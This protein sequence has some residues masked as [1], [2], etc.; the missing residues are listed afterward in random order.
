[1]MC[2]NAGTFQLGAFTGQSNDTNL[3]GPQDTIFLCRN[4]Q[5]L[6]DHNG[7]SDLSG[8][9]QPAT[10]PGI[11]WAF[12]TCAPTVMGDNLATVLT[13]PCIL[14]GATNGIWV[15][16][17]QPNGDI[18]FIN[19]GGLQ[20]AFNSGQPIL[21]HFAPITLDVFATQGFE[22]N[23]AGPCVNV[24]TGVEFKVLYMNAIEESGVS[25]NFGNDCLGKFRIEGG[26]P[27][28]NTQA[29]YTITIT[30]ASDPTIKAVIHT[31][32][33]Q[34]FHG[35][36]V[37]F[38]VPQPGT[39]D[40]TV[41]DGK[42]CGHTFQINMAGCN[43][44]DNVV[45]ALPDTVSP[46]GST[47]CIPIT[48]QNFNLV[49][50][51][52]SLNWDPTILEFNTV[53]N[54][55]PAIGTFNASNLNTQSTAEGRLGAII[56]DQVN[57]GNVISIPD[58]ETLMEICFTVIGN[59]G[60]CT[61]LG[62][63]NSPSAIN[64]EDALGQAVA[65]TAIDGQLC[66]DFLPLSY[67]LSVV[68]TT[69]AGTASIEVT[70]T[71][72]TAPYEVIRQR[73]N[74]LGAVSIMNIPT[75]GGTVTYPGLSTGDYL[76]R[77][78]DNN[79][80]GT[81]LNDTVSIN[82]QT[83]GVALDVTSQLP[84]CNGFA[85]GVV[86]ASVLIGTTPV[87]NPGPP[88][89]TFNWLPA[90]VPNPT[91]AVQTGV[92]AGA[93]SVTVTDV[94]SQCTA[95]ASGALGQP[96]VISDQ[97]VTVAPASCTGICDGSI[98][99]TSTGGTPY[100]TSGSNT[101]DYS[102]EFTADVA[103]PPSPLPNG[104]GNSNP[105]LL[106][107]LCAGSYFVTITD[108]NGCTITDEVTLNNQRVLELVLNSQSNTTCA[109]LDNGSATVEVQETPPT[110]ATYNFFW[111]PNGFTQT[112]TA[113]TSTYDDL[114]AG[115]YNVLATDAAGCADTLT[116]V[117][118]SP[119]ELE[120]DTINLTQPSCTFQ[121]DGAISTFT[122]GGS[123]GPLYTYLWSANANNANTSFV[124]NLIPGTYTITVTDVN[125]CQDSLSFDLALP[126]PPTIDGI[127][128]VSVRCGSDGC[129][130]VLTSTGTNFTWQTLGGTVLPSNTAQI[131]DLP[132]GTYVVTVVDD[133]GC[134]TQD[135]LT[136]DSVEVMAFSDTTFLLPTCFGY[137]DG[138]ISV[139]VSGGNPNY[140]FLWSPSGQ[141]TGT[142]IDVIAGPYSV[143]VTDAQGCTLTGDF[144][145]TEPP[146]I[147][148]TFPA[149]QIQA[150]SCFGTCDGQAAPVVQFASTP[151]TSGN[152]SFV[153]QGGSTDSLR[154]DLCAGINRVT[155]TD[156]GNCFLVD[157]VFIDGPTAVAFTALDSTSTS[158]NGTDDGSVTV[159]G[160]GGNGGPFTYL[161][162]TPNADATATVSN[163]AAGI[164]SVT[165]TDKDGCTGVY[166][167]EVIEP[168]PVV[169]AE[170][171]G[172]DIQCFGGTDG[173]LS[174]VVTGGNIGTII[175]SW[176]D[177]TN[178]ISTVASATNLSSG[179]YAVT[180]TDAAGCTGVLS[181][182]VLSD[183]PPV[184]GSYLPWEPLV[185]NGDETTLVI[186]TILGGAGGPYQF[187]VD[188]GVQLSQDF[189]ITVGGGE[190]YITYFD[191]RNCEYTDT[192]TIDEPAPIVVSFDPDEIEI[193][194]GDSLVLQ[195]IIT[196]AVVDSFIWTPANLLL[197]PTALNP[198]AYTFESETFSL[199]VFDENGCVGTGSVL[200]NVDPNR[201]VFIPNIFTPGNPSGQNDHFN[202]Y[203][204][205]GVKQINF[206]QVFNRWGELMYERK[207][208]FPDNDNL[209]EGWD[210]RYKGDV[211]NPG[212]YVY[213]VEVEF[214]DDRVLLYRG[215]VTVIR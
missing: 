90:S 16:T 27:E 44:M 55:H 66:V 95:V 181:N 106:T 109:K 214:L 135:T 192:I 159:A 155:I 209:S 104:T 82:L 191:V 94:S 134:G 108:A 69:C 198:T 119:P 146:A 62:I 92:A 124:N 170:G 46:P 123:G 24:N 57:L 63:T 188:F 30:L 59:L 117:I 113:T 164:Y 186:D 78:T 32:A 193:E 37:I 47:I 22:G 50:A 165:I 179:T 175:Y 33:S 143:V 172:R 201:N 161:W 102:W 182:L 96:S 169:L 215:D 195:P 121:N 168:E 190:H 211:V 77:I 2:N 85:D 36:D 72:G 15:A 126:A 208:F 71:G 178:V 14:P 167:T 65:L 162:N 213:I 93:Y 31:A 9:P 177:G 13:D 6:I 11:G 17:D 156:G 83:L 197:N 87:N 163:L 40:V 122:S 43:A 207:T 89:F 103:T 131:C 51:S 200:I 107:N 52:F 138:R 91:G 35:A 105:F 129:L 25:T 110:G 74:P 45:F 84:T 81:E 41:E 154:T 133:L 114:A 202:V 171:P 76:I 157:S 67:A 147:V 185:C 199:V 4:D 142:L 39:Y 120:I 166:S 18:A 152:F 144:T 34:L 12:Y 111:A 128:S 75:A 99:Y 149:A 205:A 56:Y 184:Q 60:E 98:S 173:E 139:G 1:M 64:I 132:G 127:D 100:T 183:P 180:A 20:T 49:G 151:P 118:T 204:G 212:V 97:N 206:M 29:V 58:D 115:S 145:L 21:L 7:D 116:V 210:G 73:I 19:N 148:N 140:N 158:C 196:G 176:S 48:V 174:V 26:Y 28:W 112:N 150:V 130:T 61:P 79:G 160:S 86:T 203:A 3:T 53:Q 8:D 70:V 10:L 80:F 187:S 137:D 153:W 141:I 189:P 38:S 23:P 54:A 125:G 68:D 88:Q 101:Y 136:L 42:S 194:L 5:I